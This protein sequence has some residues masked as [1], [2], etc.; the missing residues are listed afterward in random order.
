MERG[1][2]DDEHI[3]VFVGCRGL[4]KVLCFWSS[5]KANERRKAR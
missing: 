2:N 3:L 5:A 1:E 4:V